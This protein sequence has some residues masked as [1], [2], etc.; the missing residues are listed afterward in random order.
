MIDFAQMFGVENKG[1]WGCSGQ[2]V[3]PENVIVLMCGA[4]FC[5]KKWTIGLLTQVLVHEAGCVQPYRE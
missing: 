2:Q 4:C 3:S 1:W 5:G